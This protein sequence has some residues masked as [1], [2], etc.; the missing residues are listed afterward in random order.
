MDVEINSW[1]P[2]NDNSD[3]WLDAF[4][5]LP[6]LSDNS[7]KGNQELAPPVNFN[8]KIKK[9]RIAPIL[10]SSVGAAKENMR[11][12]DLMQKRMGGHTV[13]GFGRAS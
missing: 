3:S 1:D 8:M 6:P 2:C 7:L 11:L 12:E 10:V 5:A 9:K 4:T 13:E